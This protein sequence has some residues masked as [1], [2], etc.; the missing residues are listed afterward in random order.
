MQAKI[1]TSTKAMSREDWLE[2]RKLGIGGSDAAAILGLSPFTSAM[3]VYMDKLGLSTD[4]PENEA[5]WLGNVLEAAVADRFAEDTGL[6]V[7]KRNAIF[8]HPEHEFMLA[9][10]DRWIVG[11]NAGLEIKTTSMLTKID[12]DEGVIPPHYYVQCLHYMAVTGA[13]E[14]YLAVLVIG[15]GFHIMYVKRDEDEIKNLIE[16]EKKFWHDHILAQVPPPPDGSESAANILKEMF[17][18]ATDLS[19]VPIYG[20]EDKIQTI[21]DLKD[22]I[23]DLEKQKD[24]LEQ[25]IQYQ[26]GQHDGAEANGFRVYW[27]NQ[28]RTGIDSKRLEK[29]LPEIYAEY[30][31]PITYRKFDIKSLKGA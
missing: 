31:K 6:Q 14:W 4:K 27:K 28:S 15:R 5:I 1:L 26:I 10:I 24:K 17:P 19:L 12:F 22:R 29:E 30:L 21:L 3:S 18:R 11:K 8:K 25:E 7:Q 9:N 20:T 23:K 13:D 16:A 2:Q